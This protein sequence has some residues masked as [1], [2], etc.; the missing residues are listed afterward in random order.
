MPHAQRLVEQRGGGHDAR[1]VDDDRDAVEPDVV[2][3]QPQVDGIRR[4]AA[5]LQRGR[6]SGRR[7]PRPPA[8]AR[9]RPPSCASLAPAAIEARC[10]FDRVVSIFVVRHAKAGSRRQ[11]GRRRSP[12]PA[13]RSRAGARPTTI[14]ERLAARTGHRAVV[15]P[16]RALRADARAARRRCS[17]SRSSPTT[18][19]AEGAPFESTLDAARR[20]RRRCRAVQPR[21][22][23]PRAHRRARPP[24]HRADARRPTGARRRSGSSTR[25]T[26]TAASPPPRVEPP[27]AE[28]TSSRRPW[29]LQDRQQPVVDAVG[30]ELLVTRARSWAG[31]SRARQRSRSVR[32]VSRRRRRRRR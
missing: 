7:R 31:G 13:L 8:A 18:A 28:L 27:P 10:R 2:D 24:R 23:H 16:V 12:A 4:L 9:A 25:P 29:R 11:V 15:E 32:A 20:S 26:P 6:R 22:R 30:S 3:D 14:A 5:R 1:A 17:A 19:L 21:R